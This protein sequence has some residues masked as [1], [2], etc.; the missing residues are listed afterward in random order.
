MDWPTSSVTSQQDAWS[1][2]EGMASGGEKAMSIQQWMHDFTDQTSMHGW[3]FIGDRQFGFGQALFWTLVILGSMGALTFFSYQAITEYTDS[4]IKVDIKDR[5]AP[6][7]EAFFPSV[8][9]CNISP[10]RKSFIYWLADNL[11]LE[12][13]KV[14]VSDLFRVIGYNFFKTSNESISAEDTALLDRIFKSSFYQKGFEEFLVEKDMKEPTEM[15]ISNSKVFLD[16][17]VRNDL[18]QYDNSTRSLLFSFQSFDNNKIPQ[19]PLP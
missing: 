4:T 17:S 12:G 18:P 11:K 13:G 5:S 1:R 19:S 2:K 9:M 16:S 3:R 14:S 15:H 7:D 6:L 8:V 10:L